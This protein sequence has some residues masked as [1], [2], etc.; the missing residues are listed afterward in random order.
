MNLFEFRE[1]HLQLIEVFDAT[2]DAGK[3]DGFLAFK[4]F[5]VSILAQTADEVLANTALK[6][7]DRF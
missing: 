3:A 5:R 4:A 1:F 6:R 7:K 2:Q